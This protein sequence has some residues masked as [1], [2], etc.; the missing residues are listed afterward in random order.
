MYI[1]P[2]GKD[3]AEQTKSIFVK[4]PLTGE[5]AL[6]YEDVSL[7]HHS[8]SNILSVLGREEGYTVNYTP[9]PEGVPEGEAR[10]NS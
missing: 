9:P 2:S 10:G 1:A 4:V 6:G 8:L 3:G 7:A 5:R